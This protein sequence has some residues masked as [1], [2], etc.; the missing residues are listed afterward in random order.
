MFIYKL[1]IDCYMDFDL[2]GPWRLHSQDMM[3]LPYAIFKWRKIKMIL[4][5]IR[6]KLFWNITETYLLG[7]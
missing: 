5:L 3:T 7:I 6:A 2:T 1:F 4:S